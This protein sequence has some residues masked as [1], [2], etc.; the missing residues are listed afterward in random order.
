MYK[1][2]AEINAQITLKFPCRRIP[3]DVR[4]PYKAQSVQGVSKK[5]EQT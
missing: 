1:G 5:T 2:S 4:I 3:L